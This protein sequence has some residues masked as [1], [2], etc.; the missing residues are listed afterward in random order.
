MNSLDKKNDLD[1]SGLRT[2]PMMKNTGPL[3]NDS[4]N[5]ALYMSGHNLQNVSFY[6]D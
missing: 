6:C 3:V 1:D 2:P 4:F 5:P